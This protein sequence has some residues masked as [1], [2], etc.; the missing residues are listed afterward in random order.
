MA[1]FYAT[2]PPHLV[3]LA[4]CYVEI[5]APTEKK[6]K[7]IMSSIYGLNWGYLYAEEKFKFY[8]KTRRLILLPPLL[9]EQ[10]Q[11]G[12]HWRGNVLK[13]RR[14]IKQSIGD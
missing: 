10:H 3:N 1:L 5:E 11:Q 9:T 13:K 12:G 8:I 4:N 2:F 14:Q 7:K 6:A